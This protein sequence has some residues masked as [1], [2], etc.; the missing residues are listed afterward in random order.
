MRCWGTQSLL[1]SPRRRQT[2]FIGP[3]LVLFWVA[4]GLWIFLPA[5]PPLKVMALHNHRKRADWPVGCVDF[6]S[7]PTEDPKTSHQTPV[8][9]SNCHLRLCCIRLTSVKVF[10]PLLL[11][12]NS[13]LRP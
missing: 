10:S 2:F 4:E 5:M 13:H 6:P 8:R 12:L 1:T 3:L 11:T 7:K 9:S